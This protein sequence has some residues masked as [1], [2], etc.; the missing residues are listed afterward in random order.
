MIAVSISD[1]S[2]KRLSFSVAPGQRL[3]QAGLA[4]GLGLP[5]ECATGTCGNCKATVVN[6]EVTR[7]WTDAPGARLCRN[8][9][10]T[11]LCQSAAE[12]PV[13]LALRNG[14]TQPCDPPCAAFDGMIAHARSLTPE[15]STF[16]VRLNKPVAY[17]AGQF[18]L[19]SGLNADGPRAYSMI[20]HEPEK[21]ELT[22][23][24]RRN[25]KGSFSKVL[26]DDVPNVR[27]ITVFGPLGQATFSHTEDR[28]FFMIAGGSGIAG[29]LAI[30]H[31]AEETR[32]FE[33]HASH[34][35]F[36]LRDANDSYLLDDLAAAVERSRGK[37]S[38]TIAFSDAPCPQEFAARFPVLKF[39]EGFIHD[40][41]RHLLENE[42]AIGA[43]GKPLFFVAGPPAAVNATIHAL[44]TQ[45][46]VSPTEIRHDRFG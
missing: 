10:E 12:G 31:H 3:L 1:R 22:F 2:G 37:L 17:R 39:T 46:K 36:G 34:L 15:I 11:L 26:F 21:A 44:V 8:A 4:A 23:L 42:S 13:E 20:R 45:C 6:G 19:L 25:M 24:I 35:L 40:A 30:L 14:F 18:V 43:T 32:H 27:P 28:P 7:L 9:N 41:A 33:S 29:M 16:S 5:H 38:V